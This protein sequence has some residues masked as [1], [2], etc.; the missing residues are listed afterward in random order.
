MKIT[1]EFGWVSKLTAVVAVVWFLAASATR[2][3]WND[4]LMPDT[5]TVHLGLVDAMALWVLVALAYFQIIKGNNVC[6]E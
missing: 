3:L 2:V 4:L 6:R 1:T 5:P